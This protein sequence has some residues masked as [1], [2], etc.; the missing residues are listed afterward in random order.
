MPKTA[1]SRS[2]A[3]KARRERARGSPYP[4][5]TLEDATN[6]DAIT[7][8]KSNEDSKYEPKPKIEAEGKSIL[9]LFLFHI[10]T[11]SRHSAG[12]PFFPPCAGCVPRSRRRY[13][14]ESAKGALRLGR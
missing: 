6:L 10:L 5:K 13:G 2:E 11:F 12:Q 4:C 9:S 8:G 3:L 14:H 1:S 7:S